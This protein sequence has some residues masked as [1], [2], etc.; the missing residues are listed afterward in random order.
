MK[1]RFVVGSFAVVALAVAGVTAG[2]ALKSGLPVG[3]SP[4]AFNPLNVTGAD[5]GKK[6]CLV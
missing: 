3:K 6:R 1:N 4:G 2:E 5:A